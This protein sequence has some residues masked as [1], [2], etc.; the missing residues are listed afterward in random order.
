MISLRRAAG[1]GVGDG[2]FDELDPPQLAGA[3][4]ERERDRADAAVEVVDALPALQGGVLGDDPVE[5]LGHLGVGLEEGLGGDAQV[6]LAEA[7]GQLGLAP[8]ELGLAAGGGLGGALRARPEHAAEALAELALP[9]RAASPSGS[10]VPSVVTRRICSLPV[11]RPSRTTRL[12]RRTRPSGAGAGALARSPSTAGG[13]RPRLGPRSQA[14]SPS[15]AT[16]VE[17]E[18]RARLPI[19][20]ASRQSLMAVTCLAP[21]E[22]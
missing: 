22:A 19:S 15:A 17:H 8:D 5:Q 11:L 3:R 7:L 6:E 12:R 21:A 16:P 2:G 18:L 1:D 10:S 20:E 4:G 13:R 14:D 9:A